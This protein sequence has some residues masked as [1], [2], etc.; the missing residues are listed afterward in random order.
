MLH[1]TE[2]VDEHATLV[3][4]ETDHHD[5]IR[6]LVNFE[7]IQSQIG[8]DIIGGSLMDECKRSEL[9]GNLVQDVSNERIQLTF[10]HNRL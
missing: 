2:D 7:E 5:R 9:M 8:Q 4:D 6:R 1:D 10:R 3:S